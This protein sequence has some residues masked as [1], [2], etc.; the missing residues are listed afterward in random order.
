MKKFTLS[1]WCPLLLISILFLLSQS[2]SAQ[3]FT[4]VDLMTGPGSSYPYDITAFNGKVYFTAEADTMLGYELYVSDGTPAGTSLVKDIWPGRTSGSPDNFTVIGSQLFFTAYDSLHGNELWVTDGTSA[5][6]HMISDIYAGPSGSYPSMLTVCNS[7]LY[8]SANDSIHGTE[9]WVSDGTTSGTSLVKDI[10]AGPGSSYP[11][12]SALTSHGFVYG[13]HVFNS[14]IY[15][16]AND[17]IHGAELWMTDGTTAGT[18]LVADIQTGPGSSNPFCISDLN[19]KMIFT[20]A[21]DTIDG[22]EVWASDGTTGGT[23]LLK[24]INPGGGHYSGNGSDAADF[25]GY[26]LLN[27]KLYFSATQAATGYELW[28]TDGTTA[29]T[30]MVK[31]I[32]AG[33]GSS[34][35]GYYGLYAYN[36]KVYFPAS[37]SVNGSQLWSSDGTAA[38]TAMV[39]MLSP[40]PYNTAPTDFISFNGQLMFE[41]ITDSIN[42][43]QL[44]TSDGTAAGTHVLSPPIAPNTNPLGNGPSFCVA[45]NSLFMNADFNSIGYELW[46]YGFPLG[47]TPT[48]GTQTISAYPNPFSTAVTISGLGGSGNYTIQVTDIS[49]REFYSTSLDHPAQSASITMPE[50]ASGIYLLRVA[51]NGTSQTFKMVKN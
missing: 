21:T 13:F 33:P 27:G 40:Y 50:L 4:S 5:G 25:S 36:G 26:T 3:S 42:I 23:S 39:K 38:G 10:L 14:K 19:G 24:T 30:V 51:G 11:F 47:I 46:V 22:Y 9:L 8:F 31:D 48:S 45:G 16:N 44:Y 37:D 28:S 29:G 34:D 41:A 15:F 12:G 35:A 7:K 2:A 43:E 20:A 1:L 18:V 6:T 17:S 49:G 32:L